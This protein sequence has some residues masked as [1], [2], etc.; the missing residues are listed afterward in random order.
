MMR[1]ELDVLTAALFAAGGESITTRRVAGGGMTFQQ[2]LERAQTPG[3]PWHDA[4]S[5]EE[6]WDWVILQEQS[7]IPGFPP[8]N[9]YV[10]DSAAAAAALDDLVEARGGQ[11]VFLLTWGRRDGDAQNPDRY[12]DHQTMQEHLTEG[13]LRYVSATTTP[14]RPSWLAPAG[15]AFSWI[16]SSETHNALFPALYAG[17]G[18]HPTLTGSYLTACVIYTTITGRSSQGLPGPEALDEELRGILQQA[19]DAA[20]FEN[21]ERF[22]YPWT[23]TPAEEETPEEEPT[24]IEG[25]QPTTETPPTQPNTTTEDGKG[26]GGQRAVMWLGLLAAW[27][28][29]RSRAGKR[30]VDQ[31]S[32]CGDRDGSEP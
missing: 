10:I 1:N 28:R 22:P 27:P 16:H 20:V 2:H 14:E 6:A 23:E 21:Q 8:T 17:D 11:T 25:E 31:I 3:T 5:G 32:T 30:T 24:T 9:P 19:A 4:L 12:P 26:C 29:R 18:S 13:Y 15:P 7:Q